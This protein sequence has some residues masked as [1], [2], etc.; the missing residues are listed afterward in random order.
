MRGLPSV[1]AL[2]GGLAGERALRGIPRPRLAASV[3]EAL[4]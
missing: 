1:D 4:A 3:R 2:I